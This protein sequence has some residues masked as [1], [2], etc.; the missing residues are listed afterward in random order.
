[1]PPIGPVNRH[2]VS[3]PAEAGTTNSR[4]QSHFQGGTGD[5]KPISPEAECRGGFGLQLGRIEGT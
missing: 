2:R 4:K 5:A 1:M 3:S